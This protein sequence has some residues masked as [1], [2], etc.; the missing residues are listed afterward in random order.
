MAFAFGD[1][2]DKLVN[3]FCDERDVPVSIILGC[4]YHKAVSISIHHAKQNDE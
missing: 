4:L 2:L 3:Q 1:G